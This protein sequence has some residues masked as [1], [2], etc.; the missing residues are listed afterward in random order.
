MIL[1][2]ADVNE[3]WW[4]KHELG[5]ILLPGSCSSYFNWGRGGSFY[6]QASQTAQIQNVSRGPSA[7][8][9]KQITEV[10][11]GKGLKKCYCIYLLSCYMV[12][13]QRNLSLCLR[14][15]EKIAKLKK[16][17]NWAKDHDFHWS[18]L[19]Q[20][21]DH[22]FLNFFDYVSCNAYAGQSLPSGTP[23]CINLFR[24]LYRSGSSL[25][26]L[27]PNLATVY[28]SPLKRHSFWGFIP[29]QPLEWMSS[30]ILH[31]RHILT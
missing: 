23:Y 16:K 3:S 9:L 10:S 12:L 11:F 21:L 5:I 22:S 17:H 20:S 27:P 6:S 13:L 26:W 4:D 18:S 29:A 8:S 25:P 28:A 14:M 24:D 19:S 7:H 2:I 31:P 1:I 15:G 30:L